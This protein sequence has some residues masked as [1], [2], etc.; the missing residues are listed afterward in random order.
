MIDKEQYSVDA[1]LLKEYFPMET[2]TKGLL[3]IYQDIF[4]LRFVQ[5]KD[6]PVWHKDVT[7]F[8]VFDKTS[9][10]FLGISLSLMKKSLALLY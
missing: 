4:N 2:V 6:A 7:L 10:A 1:E 9:D 5:V 8:S 3:Q